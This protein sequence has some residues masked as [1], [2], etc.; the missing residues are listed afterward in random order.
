MHYFSIPLYSQACV[1]Q[2]KYIQCNNAQESVYKIV[3]F[4]T[5]GVEFFMLGHDTPYI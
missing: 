1:R 5:H 4:I 3:N 2:T